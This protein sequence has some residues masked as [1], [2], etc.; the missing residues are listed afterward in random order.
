MREGHS[1]AVGLVKLWRPRGGRL[2]RPAKGHGID[3]AD[4]LP[5][6][7]LVL[8]D[9][10]VPSP[11][12]VLDID[13]LQRAVQGAGPRNWLTVAIGDVEI[14]VTPDMSLQA[15]AKH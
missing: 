13:V 3:R 12:H 15:G 8:V 5:L 2:P 4:H 7:D 11:R 6:H 14:D 1:R 9:G 10:K